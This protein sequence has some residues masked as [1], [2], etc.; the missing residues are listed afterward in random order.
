MEDQDSAGLGGEK[1]LSSDVRRQQFRKFCYHEAE[2]PREVCS[3]LHHLCHEWLKPERCTKTQILDLVILEQ[4]LTVLPSEMESWVR[5]CGA[6]TS[7]QAVALAEGFLLSW[8]ENKKQAEQQVK[9]LF[10]EVA[11]NFPE[12]ES[13]SLDLKEC[14]LLRRNVLESSGGAAL[15]S[16]EILVARPAQ[17]SPVRNRQEAVAV[18][19]DQGPVLFEEV[20]VDFT[21]E[22]WALLDADQKA[23]HKIVMEEN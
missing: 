9:G 3:Q 16:E 19:P 1:T 17:P 15:L 12:R 8:A 2:G 4:F 14:F 18:A 20:A 7:S 21:E 22:E 6:E 10:V 13:S 23:L 11:A 5:E